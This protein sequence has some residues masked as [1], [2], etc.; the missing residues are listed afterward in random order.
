MLTH[1]DSNLNKQNQNLL[2]YHYTMGQSVSVFSNDPKV[3][4]R[5]SAKIGV[6]SL[7]PKPIFRKLCWLRDD[8][9]L[10]FFPFLELPDL[11][12]SPGHYITHNGV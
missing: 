12:Q 2:C 9:P 8:R 3:I 6:K 11:I 7:F 5:R 1:K 10:F 4:L